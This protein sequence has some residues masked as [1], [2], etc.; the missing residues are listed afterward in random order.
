[1]EIKSLELFLSGE[2]IEVFKDIHL[3]LHSN[4]KQSDYID[5]KM[6]N[7][8]E[9]LSLYKDSYVILLK[10]NDVY[11]GLL[12]FAYDKYKKVAY[13]EELIVSNEYRNKG[14]GSKLIKKMKNILKK[15]SIRII[16]TDSL[17]YEEAIYFYEKQEFKKINVKMSKVHSIHN[18]ISAFQKMLCKI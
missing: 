11:I 14:Y 12:V 3:K 9:F 18:D 13:L 5:L 1:M 4:I 16:E 17:N 8:R 2:N 6:N 10:R 15:K 7:Y